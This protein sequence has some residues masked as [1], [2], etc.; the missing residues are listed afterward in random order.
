[1]NAFEWDAEK[2]AANRLKHGIDFEDAARA[3]LG[4]GFLS[5][6]AR[7]DELRFKV[8]C[9]LNGRVIVVIWTPRQGAIRIISARKAKTYEQR[10]YHSEVARR[11]SGR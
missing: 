10:Q 3:L 2:G 7:G 6:S 11:A 5:L 4:P 9:V 8:L 1:M